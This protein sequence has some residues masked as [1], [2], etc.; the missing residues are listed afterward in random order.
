MRIAIYGNTH[1]ADHLNELSRFFASLSAHN[2][3]IAMDSRFHNYLKEVLPDAPAVNEVIEAGDDFSAALAISIGGD[4]TF[5]RTAR[6]VAE[7]EI[8]IIGINTGHLGYLA[9]VHISEAEHML[10]DMHGGM[11]KTEARSLMQVELPVGAPDCWPYALNEVAF[12]KKDT[13]SMLS[14]HASINGEDL[15][16]YIG[17]GLI[18]ATPTGSTGYNMSVGG[19]II[20]PTSASWVLSPIAPHSL[21][22]RPLVVSDSSLIDVTTDSRAVSSYLLSLDGRSISLPSGSVVKLKR[23]PF[24]VRVVQRTAHHF[25]S[26]LRQ[27]LLWGMDKR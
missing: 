10:A 9:D 22:M 17:D 20:E 25:A 4:G 12:L 7:R 26:S 19:P 15:T 23:A 11:F 8:P 16:S 5:L 1:Q 2:V 27:K 6:W 14:A 3:W 13:A 24:V 18:I 21:T